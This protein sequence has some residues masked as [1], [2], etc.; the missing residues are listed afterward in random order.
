MFM[1][2]WLKGIPQ[3]KAGKGRGGGGDNCQYKVQF[4]KVFLS[5]SGKKYLGLISTVSKA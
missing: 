4:E 2:S 3:Q 1:G 5:I